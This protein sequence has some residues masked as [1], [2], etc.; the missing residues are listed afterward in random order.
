[1][2]RDWTRESMEPGING[3]EVILYNSS[4]QA[5]G[6]PL[7]DESGEASTNLAPGDYT[8]EVNLPLAYSLEDLEISGQTASGNLMTLHIDPVTHRS[9]SFQI[10]SGSDVTLNVALKQSN[11]PVGQIL[12]P[13]TV[14]GNS[15]Y[16]YAVDFDH[17]V[18]PSQ[19]DLSIVT[20]AAPPADYAQ[21]VGLWG[22][23]QNNQT[24]E[25]IE[26]A[27]GNSAPAR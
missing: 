22:S 1:M 11:T 14:P 5:M 13:S 4:G 23:T 7:T 24:S 18:C 8:L 10:S 19:W 15:K 3:V 25:A 21:I 16:V 20:P 26:L 9:E 12:G 17:V 2:N 6:R 27:F